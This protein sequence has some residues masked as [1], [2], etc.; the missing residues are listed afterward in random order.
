MNAW[1]D[2]K[3]KADIINVKLFEKLQKSVGTWGL[4]G[5][6]RFFSFMIV[7]EMQNFSIYIKVCRHFFRDI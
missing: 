2:T 7:Q 6:D 4:A 5:L 1:Y 3:T